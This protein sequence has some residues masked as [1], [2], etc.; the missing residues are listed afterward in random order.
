[1][2]MGAAI[3]PTVQ[4]S[5]GPFWTF[6]LEQ[7]FDSIAEAGFRTVE[8][9][10]TRDPRTQTPET[11]RR[12]AEERGLEIAAVHGPFLV[13]TKT[14]WGQN[15][16]HKIRRGI[17]MCRELG[18]NNL[19]VHPPYLWEREYARWVVADAAS[20]QRD[21]GVAVSVETMYPMWV[22][23]RQL[24]AYRW[25]D[26]ATLFA[27]ASHIALDTSHLAVS[28]YD[29][30]DAYRILAP[31]LTHI[32]L[33]DNAVDGRDGHLELEQGK[34]PIDRFL[35]AL[36]RNGYGGA[37]SLEIAVRRYVERPREIAPMLTRTR[38]YVEDRLSRPLRL[39][40]GLPRTK[41]T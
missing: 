8:L 18:A 39:T 25:L 1:M 15:P 26:P 32:H 35:D 40:K 28:R 36:Q 41:A 7:A 19:I 29:I 2:S 5:T 33:S 23:G 30:L 12:L 27:A 14:V 31:K 20:T 3:R 17:E 10:V 34:L 37:I 16:L 24:R 21:T 4:C 6:E 11:P 22:A 13:F 9:M 38:T